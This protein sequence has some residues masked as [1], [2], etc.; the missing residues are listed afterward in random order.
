MGLEVTSAGNLCWVLRSKYLLINIV[1]NELDKCH[2]IGESTEV[3]EDNFKRPAL[4]DLVV[5][6]IANMASCTTMASCSYYY[7]Y[8]LFMLL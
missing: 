7:Y 2:A 8:Y 3:E 5:F 4:L 6:Q 1:W